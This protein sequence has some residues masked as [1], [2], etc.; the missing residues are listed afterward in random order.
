MLLPV[1][2][3]GTAGWI[4]RDNVALLHTPYWLTIRRGARVVKA[5]RGG[6]LVRRYRAVVGNARTPTPAGLAAIYE[7]V[8]Q[9]K[10][11]AF[12]GSWVLSITALSNVLQEFGGGNGRIGIHGRGGASLADPLGSA[13][14][15]GCIRLNNPAIAWIAKRLPQGTPVQILP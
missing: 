5:Y 2:P 7:R 1:R 11:N 9:P 15:H 6:K 13:R 14:S 10:P 8:R 4:P 3:N 12:L